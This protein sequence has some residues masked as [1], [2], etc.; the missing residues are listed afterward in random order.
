MGWFT[1][2][3]EVYV[4]GEA[5]RETLYRAYAEC[6][7]IYFGTYQHTYGY[8]LS[9]SD[10]FKA[11]PGCQVEEVKGIRIGSEYF[12]VGMLSPVKVTKPKREKGK[13]RAA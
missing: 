7:Y 11:H 6:P 3:V 4:P 12:A 1:K 8:Y 13:G 5:S 9:C 10:A 2:T